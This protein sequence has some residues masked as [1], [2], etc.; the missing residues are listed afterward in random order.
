[1]NHEHE[2]PR[3]RSKKISRM[4]DFTIVGDLNNPLGL[5]HKL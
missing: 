2:P 1:M 4:V 5:T 3:K